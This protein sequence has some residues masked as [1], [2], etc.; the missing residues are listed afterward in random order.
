MS[1]GWQSF[2][3]LIVTQAQCDVCAVRY[4]DVVDAVR[5]TP[6]LAGSEVLA[7]NPMS[8]HDVFEDITRVGKAAG[9][10]DRAAS[11][12]AGLEAR[13]RGVVERGVQVPRAHRWRTACLEW[14]EPPMVAANW[15]PELIV[16]AGARSDLASPGKHTAYADWSQIV[17]Y[18]PEAIV[19]MPCGF[20]LARAITESRTLAGL[21]GWSDLAAVRAEPCVCGGRKRVLQ[22]LWPAAG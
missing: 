14:I 8:I 13:Y 18:D 17:D 2:T 1:S 19:V 9:V 16:A 7:L 4:Q 10:A 6:A 20:D 5:A 21:P 15:T 22:S 3:D 11:V 12:R